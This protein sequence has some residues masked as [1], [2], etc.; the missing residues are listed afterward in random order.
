MVYEGSGPERERRDNEA[1]LDSTAS[2]HGNESAGFVDSY[3]CD[4]VAVVA[5]LWALRGAR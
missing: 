4:S 1:D 3:A 5:A 2:R